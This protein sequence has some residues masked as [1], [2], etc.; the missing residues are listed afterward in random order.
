ME[1]AQDALDAWNGKPLDDAPCMNLGFA[2]PKNA[3]GAAGGRGGDAIQPARLFVANIGSGTT[4]GTNCITH[5]A[6]C[7]AGSS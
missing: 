6:Q 4:A 7:R 2:K 3:P 1:S 5:T